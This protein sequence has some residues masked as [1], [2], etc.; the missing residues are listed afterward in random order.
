MRLKRPG[1]R[2]GQ[3][4][5]LRSNNELSGVEDQ[6]NHRIAIRRDPASREMS[7]CHFVLFIQATPAPGGGSE[8]NVSL[9]AHQVLVG[10]SVLPPRQST[11]DMYLSYVM[12]ASRPFPSQRFSRAGRPIDP[13][14]LAA[15]FSPT[16]LRPLVRQPP[17]CGAST[18]LGWI[19]CGNAPT[20]RFVWSPNHRRSTDVTSTLSLQCTTRMYPPPPVQCANFTRKHPTP[21]VGRCRLAVSKERETGR[22][23]ASSRT[24]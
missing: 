3:P 8:P 17:P 19:V 14:H 18:P 20:T 22:T 9:H 13:L 7:C 1:F 24:G 15:R 6:T 5:L 21:P 23:R 4:G 16:L 10:P 11:L 2:R 12:S